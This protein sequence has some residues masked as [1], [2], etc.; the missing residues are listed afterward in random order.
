MSSIRSEDRSLE[1]KLKDLLKLATNNTELEVRFRHKDGDMI[2]TG[3]LHHQ[4]ERLSSYLDNKKYPKTTELS[5]VYTS[6]TFRENN[7]RKIV[8]ENNNVVYQIKKQVQPPTEHKEYLIRISL[9]TEENIDEKEITIKEWNYA[10]HRI[11]QSY[12]V[13]NFRVDLTRIQSTGDTIEN[14]Y[15]VEIEV[16]NAIKDHEISQFIQLI[17]EVYRIILGTTYLYTE[18]VKEG[19][20]NRFSNIFKSNFNKKTIVTLTQARNLKLRDIVWKGIVGGEHKYAVTYKAD[21]VR[22]LL[23]ID[24]TGLWFISTNGDMDL[25]FNKSNFNQLSGTLI[26]GEHLNDKKLYLWFDCL[27]VSKQDKRNINYMEEDGTVSRLQ[28]CQQ[29]SLKMKAHVN[30]FTKITFDTKRTEIITSPEDFFKINKSF[31]QGF[32]SLPYPEDGLMYIPINHEYTIVHHGNLEDRKLSSKPDICK[33]KRP[34]DI[35]IDFSVVYRFINNSRSIQ[36][37]SQD[38]KNKVNFTGTDKYPFNSSM[39]SDINQVN[40]IPINDGDIIEYAWKKLNK[41]RGV[42]VPKNRRD[43]KINP[44]WIGIAQDNWNDV[45]E[46]LT[47]DMIT[48]KD[49]SLVFPY[50]KRIKRNLYELI[51]SGSTILDIGSGKGG[52]ILSWKKKN[53]TVIAVEP[54]EN[55]SKYILSRAKSNNYSNK[56]TLINT[57]AENS[58]LINSKLKT[59]VD[60]VT[61]MFSLSFFWKSEDNLNSLI[62]TIVS[63]LKGGGLILF[64][65]IN[66][67]AVKQL[68]YNTNFVTIGNVTM[69]LTGNEVDLT[70]PNSIVEHQTEYLVFISDLMIKL[71]KYGITL[72]DHQLATNE[73]MLSKE[74]KLYTSLYSYGHFTHDGKTPLEYRTEQMPEEKSSV[75]IASPSIKKEEIVTCVRPISIEPQ[76][77]QPSFSNKARSFIP[78]SI[79]LPSECNTKIVSTIRERGMRMRK[80]Q[81]DQVENILFDVVRIGTTGDNIIDP[82]LKSYYESYQNGIDREA[83]IND[84]ENQ[85]QNAI[86][87]ENSSYPGYAYWYTIGNGMLVT[88]ILQNIYDKNRNY[89]NPPPFS[90]ILLLASLLNVNIHLVH[91]NSDKNGH[92][93]IPYDFISSGKKSRNIVISSENEL[94]GVR[95]DVGIQTIFDDNELFI[96]KVNIEKDSYSPDDHFIKEFVRIFTDDGN[97]PLLEYVLP[98]EIEQLYDRLKGEIQSYYGQIVLTRM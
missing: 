67:D 46:P 72:T 19:L 52:D 54:N 49:I 39:I 23:A 56:I 81:N 43:D 28:L 77:P 22:K 82:I 87:T 10:R 29:L 91:I 32:K 4:Y 25:F 85:L 21:G 80:I 71:K 98:Q 79:Q 13:N 60:A 96:E 63:N 45:N 30:N 89:F 88:D 18:S 15:E 62:Q 17:E 38:G 31:I 74:S 61:L 12:T 35:T 94:I 9:S 57:V 66:G 6:G 42:M 48:G 55:N 5:N 84:I 86:F 16:I 68:F 7:I 76:V 83:T 58:M 73:P 3:V 65:T 20:I 97:K 2:K 47:Q 27:S 44:N 26:D 36:L 59:K 95:K 78:Q 92:Y 40:G 33:W 69:K 50:H 1:D 53:L 90:N 93:V 11:R 70:I 51:K 8:T 24:D 37:Q 41:D 75:I 34:E 64:A 14:S